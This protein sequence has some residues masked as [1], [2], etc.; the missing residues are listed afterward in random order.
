MPF[1]VSCSLPVRE[2]RQAPLPLARRVYPKHGHKMDKLGCTQQTDTPET[3][4]FPHQRAGRAR[5]PVTLSISLPYLKKECVSQKGDLVVRIET[6][7]GDLGSVIP[8]GSE[9]L[10]V[11]WAGRASGLQNRCHHTHQLPQAEVTHFPFSIPEE[12]KYIDS[13]PFRSVHL[14]MN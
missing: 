7:K 14:K 13:H 10:D 5:L 8:W 11:Q 1:H 9:G 4:S 3:K 6:G 12:M 2:V